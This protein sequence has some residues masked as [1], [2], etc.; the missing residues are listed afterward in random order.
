[1][2][3]IE[4]LHFNSALGPLDYRVPDGMEAPPGTV[5]VAPLG[6]RQIIGIVWEKERLPADEV[7]ECQVA[8]ADRA[9]AGAAPASRTAAADRVDGGLLLRDPASVAR[10]VALQRRRAARPRDDDRIPPERDRARTH[11]AAA[12]GRA[13]RACRRAGHDPRTGRNSPASRKACCAGWSIAERWS[14]SKWT[15]TAPSPAPGPISPSP[16]LEEE[17]RAAAASSSARSRRRFRAFPARWR[18][19]LGQDRDLFRSHRAISQE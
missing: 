8:P 6:P 12:R 2:N 5:V 15:A 18:D 9:P 11:D 14:R 10:M 3:R 1:M 4:L 19:R 13:R 7:P 17:Q 16:M